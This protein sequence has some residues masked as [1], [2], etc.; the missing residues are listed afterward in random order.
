MQ[1]DEQAISETNARANVLINKY[2]N[3]SQPNA[4]FTENLFTMLY[5]FFTRTREVIEWLD[6]QNCLPSGRILLT[7][8]F[9][10]RLSP[11]SEHL[12]ISRR[13]SEYDGKYYVID[14]IIGAEN[15]G[16]H[17][18]AGFLSDCIEAM[19]QFSQLLDYLLQA[20]DR[21]IKKS[22]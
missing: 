15:L 16:S 7:G 17:V 4:D 5:T 19:T 3:L 14:Q 13:G 6:S 1:I 10:V 9:S 11:G 22:L 20:Q 12:T 8:R 18:E 2:L 21:L